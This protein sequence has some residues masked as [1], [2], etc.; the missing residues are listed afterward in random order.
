M[1]LTLENLPRAVSLLFK[2]LD[3]IETLL[4]E[5]INNPQPEEDKL[6]TVKEAAAFTRLSVPTIYALVSK[7]SLPVCKKNKRLYFSKSELLEWIRSGRKQ[8]VS[9]IQ[10]ETDSYICSS[11][12]AKKLR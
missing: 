10:A 7:G 8:T 6:L 9:E 3:G 5:K 1:E 2:K 11:K 4:K 12:N